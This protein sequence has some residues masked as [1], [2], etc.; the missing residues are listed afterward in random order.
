MAHG[1]ELV[2]ASEYLD[3]QKLLVFG[4]NLAE[5]DEIVLSENWLRSTSTTGMLE[6]R[7]PHSG[8]NFVQSLPMSSRSSV[9]QAHSSPASAISESN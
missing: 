5:N 2:R 3:C 1:M 8:T 7:E 6:D 4:F 9:V